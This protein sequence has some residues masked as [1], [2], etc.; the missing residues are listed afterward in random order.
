MH[1]ALQDVQTTSQL[2]ANGQSQILE[3]NSSELINDVSI[4]KGPPTYYQVVTSLNT[5]NSST[6]TEE[7]V[8]AYNTLSDERL[9][10]YQEV[11]SCQ[12]ESL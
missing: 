3:Q 6:S 1:P 11:V 7:E 5:D 12:Q 4:D 9:P 8:P 2:S 10:Q